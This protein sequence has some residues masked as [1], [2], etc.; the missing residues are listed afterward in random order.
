MESAIAK[1]VDMKE[2]VE[3][4]MLRRKKIRLMLEISTQVIKDP[5]VTNP[6]I[7]NIRSLKNK[8][9]CRT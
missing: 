3:I 6:T 7:A 8:S 2:R 4:S 9:R 5:N 1:M